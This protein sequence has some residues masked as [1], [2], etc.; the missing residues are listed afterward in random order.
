MHL[1]GVD[2]DRCWLLTWT[3]YGT[4]LPGD[5]RGFVSPVP[6]ADGGFVLHNVPGTP[7]DRDMPELREQARGL[8]RGKPIDL[9]APQAVC[10]I[11]QFRETAIFRGWSLFAAAVMAN[12]AHLV[13]GV[14]GDPDPNKLLHDFKSYATRALNKQWARPASETWWTRDGSKRKLPDERAVCAGTNYVRRQ[15]RPLA[16][17]LMDGLDEMLGSTGA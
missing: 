9:I 15:H 2:F 3:T 10:V 13:V 17:Y 1:A 12:H 4:W 8:M 11:Q 5:E 6:S 14:T 16:V 7:V